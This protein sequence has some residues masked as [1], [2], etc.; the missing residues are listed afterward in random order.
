MLGLG[1]LAGVVGL[2]PQANAL[3]NNS[4]N[5]YLSP[6]GSDNNNDC[7]HQLTPCATWQHT[8]DSAQAGD[9]ILAASGVYTDIVVSANVTQV[10]VISQAITIQGGYTSTFTDPPDPVSHPTVLDAQSQGRVLTIRDVENVSIRGLQLTGG[11]VS[12]QYEH[13]GGLYV[14]N[15]Q[16]ILADSIIHQ[17]RAGYGGGIYLQHSQISL[18][19]NEIRQ[20][21]ALRGGGGIRCYDCTGS[22]S[23]NQIISN[24][25]VF[26]GGGFHITNSPVALS[27]NN[28]QSNTVSTVNSSWGGGGH[29]HNSDAN[30]TSNLFQNNSGY[31]GGGLRLV[32]S[33]ATLQGNVFRS[34]QA[35][36]GG[37]L[38]LETNSNGLLENNAL[39]D[40][41]ATTDGDGIYIR[42]A[43]PE[44][45][46]TTLNNNGDTAIFATGTAAA[47]FVNSLIANQAN[48]IINN[49]S[50]VT[51]TTT[52]W[53]NVTIPTQGNVQE[54][55][56]SSGSAGFTA[57][58]YHITAVSDAVD[59]ASPTTTDVDID[60]QTRPHLGGPDIGAD[61]WWA[62]DA[63]KSVSHYPVEPGL[64]VTY[65][66]MLTNTTA[67]TNTILLTDTLPAQVDYLGPISASSGSAS[68]NS[69][70]VFWQGSL[71]SQES[72]TIYWPVQLHNNLTP[73]T[74]ITNSATVEDDSGIFETT[75]AVMVIPSEV[76]LP[77]IVNSSSSQ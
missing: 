18:M 31:W 60:D 40:N 44:L 67:T 14:I 77:F 26:H 20:N 9:I 17:N 19:N 39:V 21:E 63:R 55:N 68:H 8:L 22:I 38:L 1:T 10:A 4:S 54:V 11:A 61:E 50:V 47:N 28:I 66:I 56:S 5:R 43:Q 76:Y 69:G 23:Q 36:F 7:T 24:T 13:G 70:T 73:G 27:A 48:G 45:R 57:D 72:V 32:N 41:Q 6:S 37:G 2:L 71:A 12:G 51:L 62:L 33:P 52:L 35:N 30:L 34:N 42:D 53:D 46:H 49:G 59:T 29:L 65:T 75:T 3:I 25:A 64:T 58:G 16:L 15:A 74:I